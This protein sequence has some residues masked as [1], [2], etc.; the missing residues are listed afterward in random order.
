MGKKNFNTEQDAIA[1]EISKRVPRFAMQESFGGVL[2]SPHPLHIY[3]TFQRA[4]Q[5]CFGFMGNV[6]V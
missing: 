2:T 6:I 3:V 4:I 5:P 1:S